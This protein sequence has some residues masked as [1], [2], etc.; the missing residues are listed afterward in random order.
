VELGEGVRQAVIADNLF[1]GK[2]QITNHSKLVVG[3][4]RQEGF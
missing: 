2:P 4:N 1:A 3:L